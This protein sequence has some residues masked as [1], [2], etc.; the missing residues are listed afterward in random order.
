MDVLVRTT[1]DCTV[2]ALR[3]DTLDVGSVAEVKQAVA[4]RLDIDTRFVLDLSD[5][6]FIDSSGVGAMLAIKRMCSNAGK[7]IKIGGMNEQIKVQFASVGMNRL[8]DIHDKP[9]AAVGAFKEES[10]S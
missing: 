2:I 8:I 4:A 1:E 6:R 7:Q 9:E 10:S 5:V 3:T